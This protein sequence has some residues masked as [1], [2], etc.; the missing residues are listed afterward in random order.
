MLNIF[1]GKESVDKEKFIFE[2]IKGRTL[3]LVPDQFSLQAE[4]DAFFYLKK[5]S[6]M[7]LRI[8]DFSALGHKVV[9]EAGGRKPQLIDKYGRHMLLT[10]VLSQV[11][12]R[13]HVYRGLNWKNGFIDMVNSFISEMKRYEAEP[14]DLRRVIDGLEDGAYLKYKLEDIAIIYDAYQEMIDG[15]YLDSE[16][17]ITF[18]GEKILNSRMV[19]ESE[20]W[21]YGF[22]TFTPKNL[23]VIERLL[24]TARGVNI[25][26]TYEADNELFALTGIV[27]KNLME[28]AGDLNEAVQLHTIE[29]QNRKTVWEQETLP[30]TLVAAS[31]MYAEAERAAAYILHMVR[32]EGMR[33][34]DMVVV[35]N[36]MELRGG[37]LRRTFL[38]WGIPV[39]MDRKRK[40]LHH[41]AVR[42]LLALLELLAGGYRTENVLRLI[43]SGLLDSDREDMEMLEN[44]AAEFRIRGAMWKNDFTKG[45][46]RYDAEALNRLNALRSSVVDIVEAA[47]AQKGVRNSVGEKIRGLYIFLQEDLHIEERLEAVMAQQEEA[48]L[49]EGAAETAQSWNVICNILEQVVETLGEEKLSDGELLKVIQ[50]GLEEVEIGLVPVSSDHVIIGTMQRTRLSRVKVLLA[51]GANDGIMPMH[52]CDEGLL[53]DREKETLVNHD[54][55]IS[56]RIEGAAQEE[57]L[58]IHRA[59][60]MPEEALYVSCCGTD[61]KGEEARPSEVFTELKKY[62]A[63]RNVGIL[64]DL[65]D[66]GDVMDMLACREAGLSHMAQMLRDCQSGETMDEAWMQAACWY[67]DND[68]KGFRQVKKGLLF[69]NNVHS[70]GNRFA[71]SLYS[72]DESALSVSASRLEKYSGCPFSHFILYGLRAEEPMHYEMGAREIG[73]VYHK[74]LMKLSGRLTPDAGSGL[75]VDSQESPWMTVTEEQV[76]EEIKDILAEEAAFFR[77]GI[78]KAGKEETYRTGRIAEICCRAAWSMIQQVRKGHVRKMYFEFPFGTGKPLPPVKVDVG[79]R[80]V[81]IQGKIDRL[82]ILRT[83]GS[84]VP[85]GAGADTGRGGGAEAI[86]IVDYKTG[87]DDID[88]EFFRSGYKLQLMIYLDAAMKGAEAGRLSGFFDEGQPAPEPA[89]VFHFK[90]KELDTDADAK[91]AAAAEGTLAQRLEDAYRL[92]GIVL[93]DGRLIAAMDDEIEGSSGVVPVKVR[94]RD[95]AL[96]PSAGG[97]L[98]TKEEFTELSEEVNRQVQRICGEICDGVI[99]I[100]PKREKKKDMEGNYRTACRYCDYR[101]ICMFDTSFE[102]CRYEQ[103]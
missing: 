67:E 31:N 101:S 28:M 53:S 43:K 29:G 91:P 82:D 16:D 8:V 47:K 30:V 62:A 37:I 58:G 52:H 22:D 87:G 27:I 89:G 74:C 92:E 66:G 50:A 49:T 94:K 69:D 78:M 5:K 73:D 21:I 76:R 1:C 79:D 63:E 51:V 84:D 13:L 90:V 81:V 77:E 33:F 102:G 64:H 97:H 99:D 86:R 20:I 54:L 6:L 12:S 26:M 88:P 75:A 18:Y 103:V 95:G 48:G 9:N 44:Y 14:E 57:W 38:R 35:C 41:A 61:E 34:G 59:L 85:D 46:D 15:K 42:F 98:M 11:D 70:L 56:K 32:D 93:N 3:L 19:A 25:V 17:Y 23:L 68:E 7:D 45:G 39:F 100:R 72:G 71:E 36:D 60:Y 55:E 65:E 83:Q 2:Q 10:R 24:K 96:M 80:Q 40:V 4:R